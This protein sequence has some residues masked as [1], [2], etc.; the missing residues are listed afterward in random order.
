MIMGIPV[1]PSHGRGQCKCVTHHKYPFSGILAMFIIITLLGFIG[2]SIFLRPIKK[3]V[4]SFMEKAPLLN[5]IY[6]SIRDLLS[7]VVGKEKK[8]NQ[9]V[10]V[11]VN[12]ISELEKVG[13]LT[14]EDLTDL[15]IKDKVSVYFPH[16]Y[17]FSGEMF[18]VP[19]EHIKPLDMSPTDAMKFVVSGGV[20]KA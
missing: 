16:S 4:D 19:S 1:V 15:G 6:T 13:F 9:P 14:Q 18:I 20:A 5:L 11:K 17:N 12:T 8:F 3:L 7:A 10:L 2:G